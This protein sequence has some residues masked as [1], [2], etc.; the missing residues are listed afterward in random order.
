M[1]STT[2]VQSFTGNG[3]NRGYVALSIPNAIG[4][5]AFDVLNG[6]EPFAVEIETG[7]AGEIRAYFGRIEESM[8]EKLSWK[9][10]SSLYP[11]LRVATTKSGA[12]KKNIGETLRLLPLLR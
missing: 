2:S 4:L 10:D 11:L 12:K 9:K 6:I 3:G 8:L 7:N 1:E 5:N